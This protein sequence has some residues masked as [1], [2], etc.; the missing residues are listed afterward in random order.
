MKPK[1]NEKMNFKFTQQ[2]VAQ[3]QL[4]N[5]PLP[6]WFNGKKIRLKTRIY[7]SN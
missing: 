6:K 7:V 5:K 1:I 3:I 2:V 4:G